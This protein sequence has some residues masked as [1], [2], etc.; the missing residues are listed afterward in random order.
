MSP[1]DQSQEEQNAGNIKKTPL[2][3]I[4]QG[5]CLPGI[6]K[7]PAF[8]AQR[9]WMLGKMALAFRVFNRLGYIDG[10][11]GHISIRDPE[12]PHTFWTVGQTSITS[13]TSPIEI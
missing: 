9:Q 11:A 5:P 3:L 13:F 6:P 1:L 7:H 12:H 10:M 8:E 4:S 2:Q